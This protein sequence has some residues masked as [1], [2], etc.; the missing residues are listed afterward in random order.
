MNFSDFFFVCYVIN[1][2]L[3]CGKTS[4]RARKEYTASKIN[5]HA[6]VLFQSNILLGSNAVFIHKSFRSRRNLI[7]INEIKM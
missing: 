5:K 7:S 3:I 6:D 2:S 4:A 1:F